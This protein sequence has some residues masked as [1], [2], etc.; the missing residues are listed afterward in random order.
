MYHR[1][2]PQNHAVITTDDGIC[3]ILIK[4]KFS[5][6]SIYDSFT[7]YKYNKGISNIEKGIV[8]KITCERIKLKMFAPHLYSSMMLIVWAITRN[9]LPLASEIR[10]SKTQLHL[11]YDEFVA[12]YDRGLLDVPVAVAP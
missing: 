6:Y 10:L 1:G 12:E 5:G 4:H 3:Y 9:R 7:L 8:S 11:W 2:I